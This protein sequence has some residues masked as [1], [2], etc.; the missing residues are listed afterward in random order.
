MSTAF[1]NGQLREDQIQPQARVP[2]Y[3]ADLRSFKRSLSFCVLSRLTGISLM[4]VLTSFGLYSSLYISTIFQADAQNGGRS[5]CH[6]F[7]STGTTSP[8]E[9]LPYLIQW[10]CVEL[11]C[12][13]SSALRL[14]FVQM[15]KARGEPF[16]PVIK[17]LPLIAGSLPGTSN[18]R[19]IQPKWWF[20]FV[21]GYEGRG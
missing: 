2:R 12:V 14:K 13:E 1:S 3:L 8:T 4:I 16:L 15:R 9:L 6:S 17:N 19:I 11:I 10:E 5:P 7:V 18:S 21:L 20:L